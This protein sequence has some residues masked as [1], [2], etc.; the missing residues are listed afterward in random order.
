MV[1]CS[2]TAANSLKVSFGPA[3]TGISEKE[4]SHQETRLLERM[5]DVE[6]QFDDDTRA[7]VTK[8]LCE[9]TFNDVMPFDHE[10]QQPRDTMF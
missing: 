5:K 1:R 3:S 10:I 7:R 2:M 4:I 6:S 9:R 8:L